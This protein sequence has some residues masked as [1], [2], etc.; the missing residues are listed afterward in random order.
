MLREIPNVNRN[1][2]KLNAPLKIKIFL[3]YLRRGVVL[4]KDNLA[5]RNWQGDLTCCFC[6]KSETINH[7][8]FECRLARS[9]WTILQLATEKKQP[10]SV[11]HMFGGWLY[12][13]DINLK[14]VF[15][16]GAAALCW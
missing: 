12:D 13:L 5:K 7:L 8:F 14:P 6:H 2:W 4:T 15:L 1:L 16:L 9:I 3:W 10:E 11:E